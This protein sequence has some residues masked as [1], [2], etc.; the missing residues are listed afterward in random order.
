MQILRVLLH[1]AE[2]CPATIDP[3]TRRVLYNAIVLYCTSAA[4]LTPHAQMRVPLW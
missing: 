4:Y 3:C 2:G 1:L